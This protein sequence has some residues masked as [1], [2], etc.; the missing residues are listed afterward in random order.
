MATFAVM[1]F[2]IPGG[3]ASLLPFRQLSQGHFV[4]DAPPTKGTYSFSVAGTTADGDALGATISLSV[5]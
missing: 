2:R 1:G 5:A 3:S 4:A